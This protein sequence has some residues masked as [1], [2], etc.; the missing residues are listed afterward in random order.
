[1]A[2]YYSVTDLGTGSPID[3]YFDAAQV[4]AINDDDW[5]V[6]VDN[7]TAFLWE[8]GQLNDFMEQANPAHAVP[9]MAEDVN[10]SDAIAGHFGVPNG[11]HAFV[12][13]GGSLTDLS[14][15]I[16]AQYSQA[17]GMSNNGYVAGQAAFGSDPK[18]YY[19]YD[20]HAF[21]YQLSSGSVQD[22][23]T[24]DGLKASIAYGVNDSGQ[25][26]GRSMQFYDGYG[27]FS[28][29]RPFLWA[30]GTMH[31]F[32]PGGTLGSA[33]RI[34][35]AGH[36]VGR[37]A[38]AGSEQQAFVY[39]SSSDQLTELGTLPGGTS[40]KARD[41]NDSGDVVGGSSGSPGG[42]FI[43]TAADGMLNLNDRIEGPTDWFLGTAHGIN[44]SGHIVGE[45]RINNLNRE[46]LLTPVPPPWLHRPRAD[47][48]AAMVWIL[49]GVVQ[50]GGGLAIT[51]GG[52]PIPIDPLG[53]GGRLS[54]KQRDAVAALVLHELAT[55]VSDDRGQ[56]DIQRA[57]LDVL[58]RTVSELK[59]QAGGSTG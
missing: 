34:N 1:L 36:V 38:L 29:G 9:S 59:E 20:M 16:G 8:T 51:P 55:L 11:T 17:F 10:E 22:L 46:Y 26:V 5:I 37:A 15:Q 42:G 4:N 33:R 45:G 14:P 7:V 30:D 28:T 57:A 25:V 12:Y 27:D 6:G 19:E 41:I 40:S 31:E 50:D 49:F 44:N 21:R 3:P 53:P 54:G 56:R 39:D 32:L 24:L 13:E 48:L 58:D 43:W 52:K 18:P 35:T 47:F 23:G 2:N